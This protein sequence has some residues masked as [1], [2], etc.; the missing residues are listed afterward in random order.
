MDIVK[1]NHKSGAAQE[2]MVKAFSAWRFERIFQQKGCG[3]KMTKPSSPWSKD[4]MAIA[5]LGRVRNAPNGPHLRQRWGSPKLN[6]T[7]ILWVR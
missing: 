6:Y 7:T 2:L 1:R 3:L 4:G 5:F